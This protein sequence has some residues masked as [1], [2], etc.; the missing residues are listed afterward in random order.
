MAWAPAELAAEG[1]LPPYCYPCDFSA[2]TLHGSICLT[3][4]AGWAS[5]KGWT[6]CIWATTESPPALTI[7]ACLSPP[8]HKTCSPDCYLLWRAM[9]SLCPC[10]CC[11][12][13]RGAICLPAHYRLPTSFP[14]LRTPYLP[15]HSPHFL[16][17]QPHCLPLCLPSH[18]QPMLPAYHTCCQPHT[19]ATSC[20]LLNA[21]LPCPHI[22]IS[23][24]LPCAQEPLCLMQPAYKHT[25]TWPAHRCL[26]H[27]LAPSLLPSAYTLP[28]SAAS[29]PAATSLGNERE[30][31]MS[32]PLQAT[33]KC[34]DSALTGWQT[35]PRSPASQPSAPMPAS[36]GKHL[37]PSSRACCL[38]LTGLLSSG[39]LL[40]SSCW[41][42][43]TAGSTCL[44]SFHPRPFGPRCG[45]PQHASCGC[46]PC[47]AG[48]HS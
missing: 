47:W 17:P 41:R 11:A 34:M 16:P 36:C 7:P 20:S 19:P 33:C 15:S 21:H 10:L 28:L 48:Y 14:L 37:S 39:C 32:L 22:H 2:S 23:S 12:H 1:S 8:L 42:S 40:S 13:T 27:C 31:S 29:L 4:Q 46:L 43:G 30:I 5:L 6:G 25:F 45:V 35:S 9:A 38:S 44:L 24:L 3:R 18:C 26:C